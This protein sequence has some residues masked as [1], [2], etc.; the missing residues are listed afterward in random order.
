MENNITEFI[1][2]R[3]GNGCN[4][5]CGNC[6]YFAVILKDRF[7]ELKIVYLPVRGHFMSEDNNGFLYDYEGKHIKDDFLD[8]QIVPLEEIKETD[9]LLYNR[10]VRDCML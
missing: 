10:L 7:P 8:D 4:W 1:S 6:Y 9:S 5:L 3:F 2:R